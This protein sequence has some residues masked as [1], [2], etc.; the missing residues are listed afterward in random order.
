MGLGVRR[1][2]YLIT[3]G[4]KIQDAMQANIKIGQHKEFIEKAVM[5]REVAGMKAEPKSE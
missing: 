1:I 2:T 3:Q 5:L 4:Q